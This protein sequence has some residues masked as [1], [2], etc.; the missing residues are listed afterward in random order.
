MPEHTISQNLARLQQAKSDIADAITTMGGTVGSGDGFEDF[1]ADIATIPS[2]G[3]F[4]PGG[5]YELFQSSGSI[6]YGSCIQ[7]YGSSY[8]SNTYYPPLVNSE[9]TGFAF[10]TSSAS[11]AGSYYI[12]RYGSIF[13]DKI[14]LSLYI[15]YVKKYNDYKQ[16]DAGT[17]L[18]LYTVVCA[19]PSNAHAIYNLNVISGNITSDYIDYDPA[20]ELIM[21]SVYYSGASEY[22]ISFAIPIVTKFAITD[23][24]PKPAGQCIIVFEQT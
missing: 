24:N 8:S 21:S 1:P 16:V 22:Y 17:H 18:H 20:G 7:L 13:D 10:S 14:L 11:T 19:D 3:G 4:I 9:Q 12:S 23:G 2:G 6:T 15:P 5:E